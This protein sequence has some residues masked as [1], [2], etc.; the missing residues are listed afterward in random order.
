[1]QAYSVSSTN[2]RTLS[3]DAVCVFPRGTSFMSLETNSGGNASVPQAPWSTVPQ[4]MM[5]YTL[6]VREQGADRLFVSWS[7][8]L[9]SAFP[10]MSMPGFVSHLLRRALQDTRLH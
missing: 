6:T 1:V 9:G 5:A 2:G 8:D 7:E 3:L 10:V 4:S